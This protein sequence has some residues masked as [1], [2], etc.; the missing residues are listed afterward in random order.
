M[1][2]RNLFP[3]VLAAATVQFLQDERVI[4]PSKKAKDEAKAKGILETDPAYPQNK[5]VAIVRP[6]FTTRENTVEFF[7]AFFDA[8]EKNKVGSADDILGRVMRGHFEDATTE[9]LVADKAGEVS[10]D[11]VKYVKFVTTEVSGTKTLTQLKT[12]QS[13]IATELITLGE[14]ARDNENNPDAIREAGYSDYSA[15][16]LV[17]NNK[18][19]TWRDLS[20]VIAGRE[21]EAAKKAAKK[22]SQETPAA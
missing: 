12:E 8:A 13:Q 16:L 22:K 1:S 15:M 20:S 17:I 21:A 19:K 18:Q 10:L 7:G 2:A 14:F 6:D 9:A 4:K 3:I 5:Q 11:E